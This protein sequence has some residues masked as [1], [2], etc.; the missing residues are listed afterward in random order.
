[1]FENST[2][3]ILFVLIP[4]L[5]M[6]TA[7]SLVY[8]PDT[9]FTALFSVFTNVLFGYVGYKQGSSL[10]AQAEPKKEDNFIV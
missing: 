6:M 3:K 1:M 2:R 4:S 5:C 9:I 7:Y 8:Y 10:P